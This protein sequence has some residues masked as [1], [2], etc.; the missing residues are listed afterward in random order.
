MANR[1]SD[2]YEPDS[3]GTARRAPTVNRIPTERYGKPVSGSIPTI[4]RSY[5]SAVTKQINDFRD[6]P[7]SLVWQRNYYEYFIRNEKSYYKISEYIHTNPLK[8]QQDKYYA[9]NSRI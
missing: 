5:K 8:W 4:I 6:T 7:G 2:T 1:W 3:K 9:K